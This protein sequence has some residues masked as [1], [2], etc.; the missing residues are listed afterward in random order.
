M[1][2]IVCLIPY[3]VPEAKHDELDKHYILKTHDFNLPLIMYWDFHD[4]KMY[5][6][7]KSKA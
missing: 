6:F 3:T 1:K 5:R 4:K 7:I 2:N